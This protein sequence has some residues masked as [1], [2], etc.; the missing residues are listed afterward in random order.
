MLKWQNIKPGMLVKIDKYCRITKR[1]HGLFHSKKIAMLGTIN[2]VTEVR[3][4]CTVVIDKW[5]FH[6]D[7]LYPDSYIFFDENI[8]V[9]KPEYKEIY[10]NT[11]VIM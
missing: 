1:V 10:F 4:E 5:H 8:P 3:D 11:E 2:K 9:E 7:D 6:P